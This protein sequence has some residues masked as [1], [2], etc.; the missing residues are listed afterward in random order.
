MYGFFH[1]FFYDVSDI[2]DD[3]GDGGSNGHL[4]IGQFGPDLRP[5]VRAQ[6][7]TGHGAVCGA[8][9]GGAAFKRDRFFASDPVGNGRRLNTERLCQHQPTSAFFIGPNL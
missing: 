1:D 7:L 2:R 4:C 6:I 3:I 5:I 9:D 8:L